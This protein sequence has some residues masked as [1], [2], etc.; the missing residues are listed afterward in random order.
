ML[1][2]ISGYL[3]M[4]GEPSAWHPIVNGDAEI[5]GPPS[6]PYPKFFSRFLQLPGRS[7]PG[8]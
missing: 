6:P 5:V 2:R 4:L 3:E 8:W 1:P 7:V